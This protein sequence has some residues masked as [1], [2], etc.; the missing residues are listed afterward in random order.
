M[1]Y[2]NPGTERRI[3]SGTGCLFVELGMLFCPLS[4]RKAA[5]AVTVTHGYNYVLFREQGALYTFVGHGIANVLPRRPL[6]V[7][8]D[9]ARDHIENLG[10]PNVATG[11]S[12]SIWEV[13]EVYLFVK[14]VADVW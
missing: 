10:H 6:G 1:T 8:E 2:L 3:P 13:W 7:L 4:Y 9:L 12:I 5:D 11:T 14:T